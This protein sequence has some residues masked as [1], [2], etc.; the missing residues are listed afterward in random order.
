MLFKQTMELQAIQN[1]YSTLTCKCVLFVYTSNVQTTD[2]KTDVCCC[3]DLE[4]LQHMA[5][6]SKVVF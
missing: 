5:D 3:N 4:T 6:K 1:L 2:K